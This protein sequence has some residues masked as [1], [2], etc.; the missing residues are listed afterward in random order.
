MKK[1]LVC[2]L[3]LSSCVVGN[4]RIQHE[5]PPYIISLEKEIDRIQPAGLSEVGSSITYIPLETSAK[6]LLGELNKVIITDSYIAVHSST[7]NNGVL[8][9]DHSGGFIR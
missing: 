3:V 2:L 4:S 8:L 7:A 1:L 9:F 5:D 6:S